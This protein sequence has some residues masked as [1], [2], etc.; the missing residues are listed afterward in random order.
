[1][2]FVEAVSRRLPLPDCRRR[3]SYLAKLGYQD[4]LRRAHYHLIF[5][6]AALAHGKER[7]ALRLLHTVL[8]SVQHSLNRQKR[9]LLGKELLRLT[10]RLI[11][12]LEA[13]TAAL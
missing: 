4:A 8:P 12:E 10:K 5:V 9:N 11:S 6:R 2:L 3:L 13:T 1:M 7:T